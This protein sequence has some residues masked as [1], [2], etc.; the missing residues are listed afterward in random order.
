MALITDTRG[1]QA[2]EQ[3]MKNAIALLGGLEK[4]ARTSDKA[5]QEFGK[6]MDAL[7]KQLNKFQKDGGKFTVPSVAGKSSSRQNADALKASA[8]LDKLAKQ[9]TALIGAADKGLIGLTSTL[10]AAVPVV[11]LV[12]A[13]LVAMERA[14]RA[15]NKRNVE[16]ASS[17]RTL[18]IEQDAVLS[19]SVDS[20]NRANE[21]S[22]RWKKVGQD[23][24]QAFE[25]VFEFLVSAS[26]WLVEFL[27]YLL[28]LGNE[29]NSSYM[30]GSSK[31][32]SYNDLLKYLIGLEESNVSTKGDAAATIAEIVAGAR[33]LGFDLQ[34]ATNLAVGT[35][36]V[37]IKKAK[38]LGLTA[39]QVA[40][41]LS[42]SWLKASEAAVKY[43]VVLS[44]NVLAG[45]MSERGYDPMVEV[46]DAMEAAYRYQL[47]LEQLNTTMTQQEM[48]EYIRHWEELGAQINEA[49]QTLFEFDEVIN[50]TAKDTTVPTILGT[51]GT[52]SVEPRLD[53]PALDELYEY[54]KDNPALMNL[55]LLLPR[56]DL[57]LFLEIVK[58]NPGRLDILLDSVPTDSVQ[59]FRDW[60]HKTAALQNIKVGHIDTTLLDNF[61]RQVQQ[62]VIQLKV[63]PVFTSWQEKG[64]QGYMT[65]GQSAMNL[66]ED[67]RTKYLGTKVSSTSTTTQTQTQTQTTTQATTK[68]SAATNSRSQPP[69]LQEAVKEAFYHF[70][71][72]PNILG[73]GTGGQYSQDRIMAVINRTGLRQWNSMSWAD[74]E[75]ELKNSSW[76]TTITGG[77][78]GFASGGIGTKEMDARL[79]EGNKAE[80]VIP[81]ET[82][83]GIG[84]L[85]NAMQEAAS[86]GTL[87]GGNEI[88]VHLSQ[89]GFF[90]TNDTYLINK[91]ADKIGNAILLRLNQ[92]G[93]A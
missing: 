39:N 56:E 13:S 48:S 91:Y 54:I 28:P 10:G 1:D 24:Q 15:A 45:W 19:A 38:E 9:G 64:S 86:R 68:T 63:Q 87:S 50:L 85:A 8:T 32:S 3:S 21:V 90:D 25:P 79:F 18:G 88:H 51:D 59:A 34:S 52:L 12:T 40:K 23:F 5:V 93:G 61:R 47:M 71:G 77:Y 27:G 31:N 70:G 67:E 60:I 4:Q 73:F 16:L 57:A 65:A 26:E 81:L 29:V 74:R 2:F 83:E 92:R 37:A 17:F 20:A 82:P 41:D 43:G 49:K 72:K 84:Y 75:K 22:V 42:A 7:S 55:L 46:S 66:I 69:T 80:A 78:F 33:Q 53:K 76:L 35:Y 62:M 58:N 14:G 30:G 11:G 44:D 36:D 6:T 89:Q